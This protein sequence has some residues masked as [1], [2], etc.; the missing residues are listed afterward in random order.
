MRRGTT[1]AEGQKVIEKEIA[2]EQ[3]LSEGSAER[4][5]SRH[6]LHELRERST[7]PESG[8]CEGALRQI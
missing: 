7:R 4:R 1:F 6:C 3:R 8:L 5:R 2:L